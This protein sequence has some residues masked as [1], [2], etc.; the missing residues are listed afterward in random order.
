MNFE[1]IKNFYNVLITI[2]SKSGEIIDSY[3]EKLFEDFKITSVDDLDKVLQKY[4][5]EDKLPLFEKFVLEKKQYWVIRKVVD[6]LIYY[7]VQE[8]KYWDV[9]LDNADKKSTIDGLTGAYNKIEIEAQIHR[10]LHFYLRNKKSLFSLMMFDIDFFKKVNDT[11]GHLAGDFVLREL[12]VL[13]KEVIRDSDVFGR[14]GGEEFIVI[15]PEAKIAGAIKLAERFRLACE[16][17][18]FRINGENLK[19]TISIGVTSA[20]LTDSVESIIERS[21]TALY[22]AKQK[23]RNRVE[24]R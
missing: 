2:D 13:T 10:Y 20:T 9:L 8:C 4:C 23:G 17:H 24:Y 22:D 6:R 21:D 3:A 12:S 15:M 14:F 5:G 1:V 7:S 16:N 11:Y 19:I 18:V